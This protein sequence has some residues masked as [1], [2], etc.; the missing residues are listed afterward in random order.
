MATKELKL[1]AVVLVAAAAGYLLAGGGGPSKAYGQSGGMTSGVICVVGDVYAA[2]API[3]LVSVPDQSVV[4]YEYSYQG[5]Q[6]RLAG[7]RTY[8]YDK[9]LQDFQNLPPTVEQ[10]KDALETGRR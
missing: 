6:I 7:A 4:V 5:R 1:I 2:Y 10:V 3:V 9:L 8:Q